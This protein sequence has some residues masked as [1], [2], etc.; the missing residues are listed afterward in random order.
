MIYNN[1]I[2]KKKWE[3]NQ[4]IRRYSVP[5]MPENYSEVIFW[6]II[7][8]FFLYLKSRSSKQC[9]RGYCNERWEKRKSLK[10]QQNPDELSSN[11]RLAYQEHYDIDIFS[12][13]VCTFLF[14]KQD[15]LSLW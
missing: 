11:T 6:C 4:S 5:V 12:S 13:Y 8:W 14:I 3:V 15:N 7:H 2:Q 10:L 9:C 1:I